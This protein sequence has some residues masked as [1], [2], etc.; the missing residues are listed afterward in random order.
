MALSKESK[1][2]CWLS[3]DPTFMWKRP[4]TYTTTDSNFMNPPFSLSLCM[5][6]GSYL[7]CCFSDVKVKKMKNVHMDNMV[8]LRRKDEHFG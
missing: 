1:A 6:L 7:S 2:I 8:E 3:L 5:P 4:I